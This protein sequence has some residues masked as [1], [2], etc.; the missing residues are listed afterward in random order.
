MKNI[1]IAALLCASAQAAT[2]RFLDDKVDDEALVTSSDVSANQRKLYAHTLASTGS[3]IRIFD[4]NHIADANVDEEAQDIKLLQTSSNK[5][6]TDDATT[7]WDKKAIY[8]ASAD[9][10]VHDIWLAKKRSSQAPLGVTFI[11]DADT[12]DETKTIHK[13]D[14]DPD[15]LASA[16]R[17]SQ[18]TPVIPDPKDETKTIVKPG[19]Y[20][21]ELLSDWRLK[22]QNKH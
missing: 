18:Q 1:A 5:F 12:A 21:D 13:P 22:K 17:L 19:F 11:Q 16:W 4:I 8:P 6:S 2:L 14:S 7:E 10:D 3:E 15:V 20:E 9:E